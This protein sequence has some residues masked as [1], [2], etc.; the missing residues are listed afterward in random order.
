[1]SLSLDKLSRNTQV[2]EAFSNVSGNKILNTNRN[3]SQIV[4][5]ENDS[6]IMKIP[7]IR[8]ISQT[9]PIVNDSQ[10]M[11]I[12]I[13]RNISETVPMEDS[14]II[15]NIETENESLDNLFKYEQLSKKECQA[16]VCPKKCKRKTYYHPR[17]VEFGISG[18]C[19]EDSREICKRICKFR[20]FTFIDYKD[21][22]VSFK[23]DDL[24][25]HFCEF[26]IDDLRKGRGCSKC[27]K[28][29][30]EKPKFVKNSVKC[31]CKF[32]G[33]TYKLPGCKSLCEHY[34]FAAVYPIL[35]LD[36]DYEKNKLLPTQIS[37][38]T[39]TKYWFY[40]KRY[41]VSY[42][43]SIN[44]KTSYNSL[45][46]YC[47]SS[48]R[49]VCDG[50][51]LLSTHPELCK[52][53]DYEKNTFQPNEVTKGSS[54]NAS[55]I[56][57]IIP[58]HKYIRTVNERTGRKWGC[59]ICNK[60]YLQRHG[61]HEE[62][63]KCAK[64]IHGD[65]YSYPEKY[66]NSTT[67]IGI[68]CPIISKYTN[69]PHGIFKQ[70][71]SDHKKGN[72]CMKCFE[73]QTESKGVTYIRSLLEELGYKFGEDYFTEST[74]GGLVYKEPLKVDILLKVK[75]NED[76]TVIIFEKDGDQHFKAMTN[77]GGEEKFKNTQLRD[78]I[79]DNYFVKRG[80]SLLRF[81]DR[82]LPTLE[83][84]KTLIEKCKTTQIYKSYDHY[85]SKLEEEIDF[86]ETNIEVIETE[87]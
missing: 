35:A 83:E 12:P 10:I 53:W 73:E 6:Q 74:F 21:K 40:C 27:K 29:I 54:Y 33:L 87:F 20:N 41:D 28:I 36:W 82:Y 70:R 62:F 64:Q 3:V 50:N 34:N 47:S 31:N 5:L 46:P 45:C 1:M 71:P 14:P 49:K 18:C 26:K 65:K 55:W 48:V 44:Y 9:V 52:E 23:C 80:I 32:L 17:Y 68:Y 72:G 2:S 4:P 75:N 85:I 22:K 37:P 13:V 30:L 63:V 79:K 38:S 25:Q 8:N 11:K 57:P 60:S 61:D 81:P 86:S 56:C 78:L 43:Q 42:E 76:I 39:N 77:W 58:E 15:Q 51:S 59:T 7:I 66:V 16:H 67:K 19:C 84:L 69:E 24:S